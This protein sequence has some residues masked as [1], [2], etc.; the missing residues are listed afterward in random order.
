[1]AKQETD[2]RRFEEL[3]KQYFWEQKTKEI[4]FALLLIS[5]LA[6]M[7]FL[8]T[9]IVDYKP[10]SPSDSFY[11]DRPS[12]IVVMIMLSFLEMGLIYGI[13]TIIKSW[14]NNNWEEAEDRARKDLG[15]KG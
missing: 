7:T 2:K 12:F 3:K 6:V 9:L 1:M 8:N 10:G 5:L 4:L 13:K 11:Y 14:I 15:Y